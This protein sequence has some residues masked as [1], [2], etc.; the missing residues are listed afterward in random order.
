MPNPF[1]NENAAYLVL[2]NH[3]SQHSLWPS[4]IDVP[5]GWSVV[6]GEESRQNCLTYI[7][8]HWTDMR[9]ASLIAH[10]EAGSRV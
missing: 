9:P 7:E 10:M 3:E 6:Y 5:T 8:E 2:V 4:E 1:E